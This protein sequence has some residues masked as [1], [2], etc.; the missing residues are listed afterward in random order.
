MRTTTVHR[1]FRMLESALK[2]LDAHIDNESVEAIGIMIN[3][4]MLSSQRSFHTPEH[5]FDLA[6]GKEYDPVWVLAAL[7][8]D[9]VYSQVDMGLDR[10]IAHILEPYL[11]SAGDLYRTKAAPKS[12]IC[13][14][15]I[16]LAVFG[17]GPGTVLNPQDGANEFLSA[18]TMVLSL[19]KFLDPKWLIQ[20]AACIELTIP[21]RKPDTLGRSVADRL[22]AR[23]KE[24]NTE[25]HPPLSPEVLTKAVERAV[26]FA[27]RDVE[28]FAE[29]EV[30]SFLEN[31]WKLLPESNPELRTVGVYTLGSYRQAIQK[32]HVF[33]SRLDP[34]L[35]FGAFGSEPSPSRLEDLK[36]RAGRNI[37]IATQYLSYKLL[38]VS[39]LEALARASGGDVP[40]AYFVGNIDTENDDASL[41]KFLPDS[42]SCHDEHIEPEL[43]ALLAQGRASDSLFDLNRSPLA[44]YLYCQLDNEAYESSMAH[45]LLYCSGKLSDTDYLGK[46]PSAVVSAVATAVSRIAYTRQARIQDLL[47]RLPTSGKTK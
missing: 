1:T 27:N 17:I 33:M 21:F 3:R 42:G 35:V 31:T 9:I 26:A 16:V 34:A 37:T 24:F 40:A 14:Y 18:L 4:A 8:H 7:F 2:T 19:E 25:L 5:V 23:L 36:T 43:F 28:N 15:S 12:R 46:L 38:A 20:V 29:T 39:L 32:M 30:G 6:A 44:C 47:T 13:G 41:I 22:Y 45:A 11:E 10:D